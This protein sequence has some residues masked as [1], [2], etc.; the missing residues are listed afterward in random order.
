MTLARPASVRVKRPSWG[1]WS[2]KLRVSSRS[3]LSMPTRG[4]V[5]RASS[6]RYI[7]WLADTI[8]RSGGNGYPLSSALRPVAKIIP[9]SNRA[10]T[11]NLRAVKDG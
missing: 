4:H 2:A 3:I 9:G 7:L 11:A 6:N 1:V 5:G 8:G 10:G